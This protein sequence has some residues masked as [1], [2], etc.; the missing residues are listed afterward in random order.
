MSI[1]YSDYGEFVILGRCCELSFV[2]VNL[3]LSMVSYPLDWAL[4]DSIDGLC[5]YLKNDFAQFDDLNIDTGHGIQKCCYAGSTKVSFPHI[6]KMVSYKQKIENFRILMKTNKKVLFIIKSHA[7]SNVTPDESNNIVNT[8]REISDTIDFNILIVNEYD[9]SWP[10]MTGYNSSCIVNNIIKP[11]R[12]TYSVANGKVV[13][14]NPCDLT[15]GRAP[16]VFSLW[17]TIILKDK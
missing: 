3:E 2:F 16:H 11:V 9:P 7:D 15:F 8:L 10:I 14:I 4:V 17:R 1:N 6:G 5:E 13:L 12:T